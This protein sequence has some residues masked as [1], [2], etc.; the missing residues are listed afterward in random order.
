M[1]VR[2]SLIPVESSYFLISV[3][4]QSRSPKIFVGNAV[5]YTLND[6]TYKEWS[7]KTT[8]HN[9]LRK[10]TE[11]P[12][13][14]VNERGILVHGLLYKV[15]RTFSIALGLSLIMLECPSDRY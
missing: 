3:L 10:R 8:K 4:T 2:Y 7:S 13:F 14:P 1:S 12:R 9:L 5:A 15:V 11:I 6:T